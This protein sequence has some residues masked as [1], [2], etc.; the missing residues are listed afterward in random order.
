LYFHGQ[1]VIGLGFMTLHIGLE[2]RILC[3]LLDTGLPILFFYHY[4]FSFI[5]NTKIGELGW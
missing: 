1:P 3:G 5:S 2:L 4:W